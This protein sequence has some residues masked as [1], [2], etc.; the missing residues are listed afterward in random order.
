MGKQTKQAEQMLANC[1]KQTKQ[2]TRKRLHEKVHPK[3]YPR[4]EVQD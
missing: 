3:P 1:S 2:E 4:A